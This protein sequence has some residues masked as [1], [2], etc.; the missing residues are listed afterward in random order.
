MRS[1]RVRSIVWQFL[2]FQEAQFVFFLSFAGNYATVCMFAFTIKYSKVWT[3][4]EF[5][6]LLTDTKGSIL[7]L[8][9]VFWFITTR[10]YYYYLLVL[11]SYDV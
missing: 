6:C 1:L 5:A 11:P 9:S 3:V 2:D 4:S 7:G 10:L 8:I